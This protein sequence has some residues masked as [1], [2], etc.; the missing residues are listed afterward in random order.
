MGG[1]W[2]ARLRGC[3]GFMLKYLGKLL[4]TRQRLLGVGGCS[5]D[6]CSKLLGGRRFRCPSLSLTWRVDRTWK[7]VTSKVEL[8]GVSK[9]AAS[10][11]LF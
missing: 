9:R 7:G 3:A 10:H 1:E 8:G 2:R 11:A 6:T 4:R 5:R